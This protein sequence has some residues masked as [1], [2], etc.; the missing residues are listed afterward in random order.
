MLDINMNF[1]APVRMVKAKVEVYINT[2]TLVDTFYSETN[3]VSIDIERVGEGKFFGYGICQKVNV[4]LIDINRLLNYTTSYSLKIYFALNNNYVNMFP[5]FHITEVHRDE[6]T[7]QLSITAYDNIYKATALTVAD[8]DISEFEEVGYNIG[9][10]AGAC[11][12]LIGIENGFSYDAAAADAFNIFYENGANFEGTEILRDALNAIAEATQTIYYITPNGYLHFKRLDKDGDEVFTINKDDY[13]T[14]DTRD[15]R[16]LATVASVTEL[17]DNVSASTAA[18]GSTQYVRDNPFWDLRTDVGTLVDNALAAV[19]GLTIGQFDCDWR[20]NPLVEIGDK[21]GLATKDDDTI[22]TYLLDDVISYDGTYSQK[23]KWE[24]ANDGESE[25]NPTSLGEILKQTYARVDKANK[26]IELV[27]SDVKANSEAIS[28]IYISIGEINASVERV[29]TVVND[30][31][32]EMEKEIEELTKRV[33]ATMTAEEL[34]ILVSSKIETDITEV[35]TTTGFTFNEEGLTVSKSGS[36]MST[37][38]TEDGM[39]VYRDG[40]AVLTANNVGVNATNLHA[41]TY[42]TIGNNSRFEDYKENRT[43]CFWIGN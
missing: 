41:T 4:K 38:I 29:E 27:A 37:L 25:T 18:T 30:E 1:S 34:E 36:E 12:N 19:G 14:L 43:G 3:L 32:D 28:G 22:I 7:N 42:L 2:S 33:D 13:F 6:N 40:E 8:I 31:V 16:R 15:N 35:T 20:G 5:T 39:T 24:Y 10:F 17:G 21:I 9:Q 23:T 26:E 11:A